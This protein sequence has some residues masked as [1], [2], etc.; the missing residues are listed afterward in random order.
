[1][2]ATPTPESINP[3]SPAAPGQGDVPGST[4]GG[5]KPA[6]VTREEFDALQKRLEGQSGA[7]GKLTTDLKALPETLAAQLQPK[8]ASGNVGD[9]KDGNGKEGSAVPQE[10]REQLAELAK[11][12]EKLDQAAARIK[13][14][15]ISG[16]LSNGLASAGVPDAM[17]EIIV[18][19]ILAREGGKFGVVEGETGD[20]VVYRKFGEHDD[21]KPVGEF[22]AEFF[23]SD[24][25]KSLLPSKKTPQIGPDGKPVV[26]GGKAV[27]AME[28]ATMD[29]KELANGGV[30]WNGE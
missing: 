12:Q 17:R 22:L 3:G 11:K 19:G 9:G 23:E 15:T 6:A 27:S 5:D 4:T 30:V 28:M 25:G 18:A 21:P 1:M 8:A 14:Q 24:T 29:P 2:S 7:I 16:A 20:S 10:L 13:T 26:T